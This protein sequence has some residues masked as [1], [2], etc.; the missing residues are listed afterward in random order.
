MTNASREFVS[1]IHRLGIRYLQ[2][3]TYAMCLKWTIEA[4]E[5]KKKRGYNKSVSFLKRL[6]N[7]AK[8]LDYLDKSPV[9]KLKKLSETDCETTR[10]I[11]KELLDRILSLTFEHKPELNPVIK[12]AMYTGMRR[13]EMC[14]LKWD[15]IDMTN[16]LIYI[17]GKTTKAGYDRIVPIHDMRCTLLFGQQTAF[18][19]VDTMPC[20]IS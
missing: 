5:H 7:V 12:L 17:R 16:K 6:F 3:I 8:S 2:D 18:T 20:T 4:N 14:S 9:D 10:P 1:Y 11:K 13:G 15:D 19:K